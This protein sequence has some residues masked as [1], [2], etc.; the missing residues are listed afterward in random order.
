MSKK[1]KII[2]W[3]LFV[4]VALAIAIIL[5]TS[6]L[7]GGA[8]EV[9]ANEFETYLDNTKYF[10]S[11]G[12]PSDKVGTPEYSLAQYFTELMIKSLIC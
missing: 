2:L 4:V 11:E 7:N 10:D 1:G 8:R 12:K 6:N 5:I 9:Y 3:T